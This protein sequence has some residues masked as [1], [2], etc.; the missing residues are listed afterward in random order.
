LDE[1]QRGV[2]GAKIADLPH[3]SNRH[4]L[5]PSIEGS[6][7]PKTR[8]E[9][10]KMM[11]VGDDPLGFVISHNLHRRHLSESQRTMVAAKWATLKREDT[12]K[13]NTVPPIGGTVKASAT[14][15]RDEASKLLNVGTSSIDRA[16]RAP[17]IEEYTGNDPLGFVA[18]LN[19]HRRHD[20]EN[21]RA[22]V[23]ARM[24]NLKLGDNQ[25]KVGS[26][27]ETPASIITIER[28]AE[29]AG[30]SKANIKRAKPIVTTGIPELQDM[31]DSGEAST[32]SRASRAGQGRTT[33]GKITGK[34]AFYSASIRQPRPFPNGKID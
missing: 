21:E 8:D 17:R 6:R 13:Q 11:N 30:T 23:G 7:K 14:K 25:H 16:K 19:D 26:S 33:E 12:L 4:N 27:T 22:M 31:V 34:V 29:L 32:A 5:D 2:V 18:S 15:T 3:G 20:T 28:A 24:A 9:V 10:A 1:T